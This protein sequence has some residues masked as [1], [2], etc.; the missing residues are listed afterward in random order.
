MKSCLK[1]YINGDWVDP[2]E[3]KKTN[4]IN[5]ATEEVIGEIADVVGVSKR[6]ASRYTMRMDFPEPVARLRSGPIWLEDQVRRWAVFEL[7]LPRGRP[8]NS[9][10][11]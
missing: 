10:P 1:F 4:V 3:P 7:P 11:S 8:P 9:A 5:P 6:T 2:I